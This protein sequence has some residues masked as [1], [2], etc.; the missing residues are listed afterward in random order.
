MPETSRRLVYSLEL[1]KQGYEEMNGL[2]VPKIADVLSLEK[3]GILQ[4]YFDGTQEPSFHFLE[5]YAALFGI[6]QNWLKYGEREPFLTTEKTCLY[7]TE[8]LNRIKELSPE[9]IYFIRSDKKEGNSGILLKL[10]EYKY[11]YFPKT[12]YISSHVGSTGETQ[13]FEFYRL[14]EALKAQKRSVNPPYYCQGR[15]VNSKDFNNLFCG[16]IYPGSIIAFNEN[17]WWDDFTD[18]NQSYAYAQ[19]YEQMYGKEFIKAQETLKYLWEKIK[20]RNETDLY[21]FP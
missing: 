18:F 15:I 1:M 10:S 13:I 6:N 21:K 2:S 11:T 9:I 20:E 16:K 12:W 19:E 17:P 5:T 14:I 3:A 7:A 4:D 8:Y